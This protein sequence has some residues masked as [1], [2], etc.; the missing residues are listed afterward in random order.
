MTIRIIKSIYG[1]A[2]NSK[3]TVNALEDI[4]LTNTI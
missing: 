4:H 2:S 1:A 3:T